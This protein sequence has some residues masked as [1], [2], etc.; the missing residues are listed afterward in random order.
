VTLDN[1]IERVNS[2]LNRA[3]CPL[4]ASDQSSKTLVA[5]Y[6]IVFSADILIHRYKTFRLFLT[7][8]AVAMLS[9]YVARVENADPLNSIALYLKLFT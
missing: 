7:Q 3:G 8:T 4:N 6:K 9:V 1:L 5:I 2:Q